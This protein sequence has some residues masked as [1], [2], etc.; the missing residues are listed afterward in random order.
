MKGQDRAVAGQPP[1]GE[2][3][4][5]AEG[6][7]P[8]VEDRVAGRALVLAAPGSRRR[9]PSQASLAPPSAAG[10]CG[11]LGSNRQASRV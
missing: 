8:A 6:Q 3:L 10:G 11:C 7:A 2:G 4:A 5:A 9:R 1:A